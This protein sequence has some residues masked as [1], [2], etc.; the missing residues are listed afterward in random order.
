MSGQ[1][2]PG[3]PKEDRARLS[4]TLEWDT[5][6]ILCDEAKRR[7]RPRTRV[8]DELLREWVV[9]G[10]TIQTL[11]ARVRHLEAQTQDQARLISELQRR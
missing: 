11:S 6:D 2:Q 3:R 7:R 9:Q 4:S 10:A 1:G 8:L 5:W